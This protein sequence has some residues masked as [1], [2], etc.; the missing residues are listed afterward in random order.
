MNGRRR[1]CSQPLPGADELA[2]YPA[3]EIGDRS[4]DFVGAVFLDEVQTPDG[5]LG[6]VRPAAAELPLAANQN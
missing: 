3:H 5:E 4:A 6:L 2:A 1:C